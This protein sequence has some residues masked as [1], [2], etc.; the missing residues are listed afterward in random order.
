MKGWRG[1]IVPVVLLMLAEIAFRVR[2][3]SKRQPGATFARHRR[4][5]LNPV[6]WLVWIGSAQTLARCSP[7]WRSEASPALRPASRSA[8]LTYYAA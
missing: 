7:A 6:G 1:I 8:P 5:A 2:G 4:V 3:R